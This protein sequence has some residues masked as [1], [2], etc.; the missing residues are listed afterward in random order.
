MLRTAAR[1]SWSCFPIALASLSWTG[2]H[3]FVQRSARRLKRSA[4][5]RSDEIFV[6]VDF[7]PYEEARQAWIDFVQRNQID[8]GRIAERDL[9]ID[10][11]ADGAVRYR[12]HVNAIRKYRN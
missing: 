5:Q 10:D 1:C 2:Q 7:L 6:A 11:R 8:E 3:A 12:V 9:M 4:V